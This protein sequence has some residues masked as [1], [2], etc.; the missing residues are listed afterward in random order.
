VPRP[1][2]GP[3]VDRPPP[4][5]AD[6]PPPETP[7]WP[8]WY[9]RA[10]GA[11]SVPVWSAVL[12]S[13]RHADG[14]RL[15]LPEDEARAEIQGEP[16]AV[17]AKH[18]PEGVVTTLEVTEEAAPKA[19][20]LWFAELR[21]PSSEPPATVLLAFTGHGVAPGTLL[22]RQALRQVDVSSEDQLGAYRW[23]P[24]SGF[25]DQIYVTP[26]WRRRSIG[27]ALIAAA[28]GLVLARQWPRMWSDGQR[29]AEGDRMRD[30]SRWTDRTDE[31]T[32]LMPPMTPFDER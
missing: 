2:P 32:H 21:E 23:I 30:A 26:S 9:V 16:L 6:G 20:P 24:S 31:L 25:V 10:V 14:T 17:M 15:D 27:T 28:S 12:Q 18:G 5:G 22:D 11:G 8:F 19:P 29:T 4:V 13:G 1:S 3:A 7:A